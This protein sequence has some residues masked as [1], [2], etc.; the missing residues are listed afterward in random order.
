[1]TPFIY[2]LSRLGKPIETESRL[3]GA[4]HLWDEDTGDDD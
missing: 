3:A 4:W 2:K 1:M